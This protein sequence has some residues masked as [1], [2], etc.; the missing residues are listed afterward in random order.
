MDLPLVSKMGVKQL[1]VTS[2]PIL[3]T[4]AASRKRADKA[5]FHMMTERLKFSANHRFPLDRSSMVKS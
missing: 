3:E 2:S 1:V 5:L 4:N